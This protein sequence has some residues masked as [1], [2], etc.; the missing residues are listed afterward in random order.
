[1]SLD[2]CEKNGSIKM[3]FN[4]PFRRGTRQR[5]DKNIHVVQKNKKKRVAI[6]FACS[7]VKMSFRRNLYYILNIISLFILLFQNNES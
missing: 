7:I 1:M 3:N 4:M 2:C 6:S 5:Y